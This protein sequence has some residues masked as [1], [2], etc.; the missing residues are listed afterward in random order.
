MYVVTRADTSSAGTIAASEAERLAELESFAILDTAPEIQF[1]RVVNLARLLFDTPTA[2]V[3]LIDRDRQWFKAKSGTD[4]DQ[5]PREHSFCNHAMEHD[6]VFVVPDARLDPRFAK[7]PLVVGTPN[8]RFYAGAPLRSANGHS[9]GAVCVISPDPRAE[10][11]AGDQEKLELL[12]SIVG[13]EMELGRQAHN[14]QRVANEK[15]AA[16]REAHF[17]IKNTLDYANLLTDVASANMSTEK[18]TAVAMVAWKQYSEAGG[19]LFSS[20]KSLRTRLT[21]SEYQDL[22]ANMPGF[23]I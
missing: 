5:G 15:A 22:I 11:P 12:A 8:I 6:G 1:D 21:A 7:N 10:F 14:A 13:T 17:R 9:L 19:V 23:A 2:T 16:L 20:I 4:Q 3:T 18:L